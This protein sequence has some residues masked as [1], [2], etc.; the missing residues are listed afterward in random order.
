MFPFI[1]YGCRV[2]SWYGLFSLM[3]IGKKEKPN[4]KLHH[5]AFS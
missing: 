2:E 5:S 4:G 1:N 3:E